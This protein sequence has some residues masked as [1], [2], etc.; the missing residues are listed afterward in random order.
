MNEYFSR[1]TRIFK[2]K[3][4]DF[5]EKISKGIGYKGLKQ[6]KPNFTY[7]WAFRCKN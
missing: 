7:Q 2:L 5:L 1:K 3:T 6:S 4:S